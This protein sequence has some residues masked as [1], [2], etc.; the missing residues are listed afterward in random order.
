LLFVSGFSALV[1]EVVY[2]KLLRYWTGNTAAAVAAVLCAYMA[3]LA[4]GS[5][6]AGKWLVGRKH[7]LLLYGGM[8]FVVGIYSAGFPWLMRRLEPAYLGL[9]A[10]LGPDTS[11]ALLAH[12]LAGGTLLLAPTLLMGASFPVAVR[13]ASQTDRD[14][15]EV[16]EELYAA[17]LAGAGLGTLTSDFFLIPFWGLG[18]VLILVAATN[19]L[20]AIW[21]AYVQ[22]RNQANP[23]REGPIESTLTA[24]RRG[25][26]TVV[27]VAFASGFLVL[28][29]EIVWTHMAGQF[30]DN[31]VYGFAITLFAVI[32]GLAFGALLVARQL[33]QRAAATLLPWICLGTGVLL[34]ALIPFWDNARMLA[35]KQPVWSIYVGM[36]ILGATAIIL[37][38][39]PRTLGYVLGAFPALFLLALIYRWSDPDGARF[40]AHHVIGFSVSC[41]FM[42]GPATLMGMVFPLVFASYLREGQRTVALLY[43]F[44]TVGALAGTVTAT[45]LV[46]PWL[47][48]ERSGRAVGLAFFA[49]GLALLASLLKRRWVVVLAMA[50]ALMWTFG[51]RRWNM[52]K[53]HIALGHD[54]EVVYAEED[55]NGGV[56]TVLQIVGNHRLYMNGLFE[57]SNEFEVQTQARCALV[58]LLHARNFGR[59]VVIGIGSGQTAG[60]VGLF[61]F[62]TIDLVDISPR[63]VEAGRR[64]FPDVNLNI[65]ADPR[66][67]VH[68]DDGRHYLLTHPERLSFLSIEVSRLWVSGEGNLY[69]REFYEL[70][71]T[72][73]GEGGVLQQ[74]V[75]L[76]QLSIP[77]TLIIL[78]TVRV[79]FPYVALFAGPESGMIVASRSPLEVSA[80][81]L[82]EMDDNPHLWA[83]LERLQLPQ[84][85]SLLGDCVLTPEGLDTLLEQTAEKR[86]STDLWPH[87]EYSNARYYHALHPSLFL[88]RF[89]VS[90]QEF[91]LLPIIGAT[92][93]RLAE[94]QKSARTERQRHEQILTTR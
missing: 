24:D 93:E 43:A 64:F 63:V 87:L 59:A 81:R 46:L 25:A 27:L 14:R 68:I 78:R 17:N 28:F 80:L 16:A 56:T 44:N 23:A 52:A 89:L 75:P 32:A 90:A 34:M 61:P 21:A 55:L 2:V 76:F 11:W 88:R 72:R 37:A 77:D 57:A 71:S 10:R 83:L 35:I 31:S 50:P 65:F 40:W 13:A 47:G 58:P 5:F 86:I 22:W 19:T 1:L 69:T 49:L 36:A 73:L 70:C 74:W 48:V 18:N 45:F 91:R 33:T 6:G 8:E 82:Q 51:V 26:T 94:I 41:L 42:L 15:P 62:Q 30:L 7:L 12:F 38:P 29:Q 79:V 20:V 60:I 4:A 85:A 84:S 3:G 54:G 66:V 92:P 67:K 53:D 39:R 9:T